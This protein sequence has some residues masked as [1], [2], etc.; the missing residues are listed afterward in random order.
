MALDAIIAYKHEY[1]R[2]KAAQIDA[3]RC[4]VTKAE[5][6]LIKSLMQEHASI[7]CEIKPASPSKGVIRA[8]ADIDAI[9][10]IY[11]PFANAIS[12]LADE[13]FFGGSLANVQKVAR[14]VSCPVLAKDVVVSPQQIIEARAFG[15]HA[16]LLMLSVLD[17]ETY[18]ACAKTAQD[19]GMDFIT[20]VHDE[21]E[22]LRA[23]NFAA[24]IIGINNRNLKTLSIDMTTTERLAPMAHEN[25]VVI[26]ES[27][28]K[29]RAQIKKLAPL[30]HGFLIGTSL[31][32]AE[33]IDLALRELVF[34]RVKICGLTNKNDADT[35]YRA[36]AYYGG[37]NF[38]QQSKRA[39]QMEDAQM[40]VQGS[41]LVFGGVFVNQSID[42]VC[43]T[44]E[45]LNLAF[46]QIHG[47]ETKDYLV[48]LR[49][50]LP[51]G[52][53]IWRAVRVKN[54]ASVPDHTDADRILLDG[55]DEN[56]YGGS[57]KAFDWAILRKAKPNHF[58]IAGGIRPDNAAIADS[59][60][61]FA[62]DIAS[63]VEDGEPRKK[64]AA[65]INE[66]FLHLRPR[67]CS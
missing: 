35:A 20:E 44:A 1:L 2:S 45:Q 46:V 40:I 52:V 9:A 4:S 32:Q 42:E 25:A 29:E 33:R 47:D 38:A 49:K 12:V 54:E 67:G 39:V 66:L 24:P 21:S 64:S 37:L 22:I 8:Q 41:P 27:G 36:G 3:M 23:N 57:G 63:G 17:D 28:I 56:N 31:M 53:E 14:R 13:K 15:A 65:L 50:R 62:I 7:I 55:F 43:T 59:F 19:L 34:G 51:T 60:A 10:D 48:D 11:A 16:V 30:V 61:P 18:R 5:Q 6:S 58:I 26:A